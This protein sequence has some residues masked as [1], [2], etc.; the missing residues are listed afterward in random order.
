M[1]NNAYDFDYIEDWDCIYV[2]YISSILKY[3]KVFGNS[4]RVLTVDGIDATE[5]Q[6]YTVFSYIN[7]ILS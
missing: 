4:I 2:S 5:D 6:I 3:L 7:S 1:A